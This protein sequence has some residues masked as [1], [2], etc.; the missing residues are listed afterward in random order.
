V[1][2]SREIGPTPVRAPSSAPE[3][4]RLDRFASAE[5][6]SVPA[7][8]TVAQAQLAGTPETSPSTPR[9]ARLAWTSILL[10]AWLVGTI[11]FVLR[12]V[13]GLAVVRRMVGR[14]S[15]APAAWTEPVRAIAARFGVHRPIR[16]L[17]SDDAEMPFAFGVR[18]PVVV[19]PARASE[20][21]P[22]RRE[23]VLMHELAHFSRGDVTMNGLSQL[24]RALYWF[25]PLAWLAAH[26]LRVE[27]ERASDDVV[28]RGG[29]LPSDYAEHL[30]AIVRSFGRA[31]PAPALAMARRSEFEG[32]LLAILEPRDRN[33]LSR[34]RVATVGA[35]SLAV[36]LPLS[37][38]TSTARAAVTPAAAQS[39]APAPS[40][41]QQPAPVQSVTRAT[42]VEQTVSAKQ[43]PV[44]ASSRV[45][46]LIETLGDASAEVRVAA[47]RSLGKL[48]DP[49]AIAALAKALRE[50]TDPRVREAAAWAL[51]EIDDA[52]AVPALLE[53]LKTERVPDV[54]E[55]IVHAL[56]EIDDATAVAGVAAAAKDP[57]P[58]VR[59]EVARALGEFGDPSGSVALAGMAKDE[60]V[61]VRRNVADALDE[62]KGD[63]AYEAL[64]SLAKDSDAE[65]RASA[66]NGLGNLEDRRAL[67]IFVDALKDSNADVRS[68]AADAIDEIDGLKT[69]PRGL[70]EALTDENA[71][72][73]QNAANSLGNIGDEA[74]VPALRKA[75]SDSNA[76]VRRAA[77]EAL[78]DIGGAQAIAALMTL[79][80]DP[81]P[82]IRKIAVE[83]LGKRDDR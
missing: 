28:L 79:L 64:A 20:W 77:A 35:L 66:I 69:A 55:Q 30:L 44:R 4:P 34:A 6:A 45:A 51:G 42:P 78:S 65:V 16:V 61:E 62:V 50:D 21:T 83:A 8:H 17:L 33:T 67:S 54:R 49:A 3:A 22:E 1:L 10:F 7:Q 18:K 32:R 53:A 31:L 76:D 81:D 9:E 15:A 72:V 70:I 38:V 47:V 57:T 14:A 11:L 75:T 5:Q 23:A 40:K 29:A 41:P 25:H 19:L 43:E 80:K 71:D 56:G 27:G 24:A 68:H 63:G 52:R 2:P 26:R 37:A 13:I 73:R 39:D 46:A 74:A 12:F 36:M 60:D 82:E 48:D 58:A 59:R